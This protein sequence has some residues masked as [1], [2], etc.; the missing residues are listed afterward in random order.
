MRT[1]IV[2]IIVL[3]IT[4]IGC[5]D[6]KKQSKT[7]LKTENKKEENYTT[8]IVLHPSSPKDCGMNFKTFFIRFSSDSTFQISRIKF[9]LKMEYYDVYSSDSTSPIEEYIKVENYRF[10]DLSIDGEAEDRET[11]RFTSEIEK[12]KEDTYIYYQ[13][14]IDNGISVKFQFKQINDCWLL[15]SIKDDSV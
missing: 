10:F 11:N 14:G 2:I 3:M 1:R 4:L 5:I 8:K 6:K 9:P 12:K 7:P 15:E 13:L